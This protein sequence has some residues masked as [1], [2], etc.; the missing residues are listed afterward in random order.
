LTSKENIKKNQYLLTEFTPHKPHE[1]R[2]R[3]KEG[4]VN[5][6]MKYQTG[7]QRSSSADKAQ[8]NTSYS[9]KGNSVIRY[10]K[11]FQT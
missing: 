7:Y 1:F 5:P 8:K 3:N 6:P 11:I 9:Q 2:S 10:L 4:D